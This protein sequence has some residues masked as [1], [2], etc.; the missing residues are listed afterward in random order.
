ML[1]AKLKLAV[2]AMMVVAALG[3]GGVAYQVSGPRPAQAAPESKPQPE[4]EALK[5][6]NELL[7]FNLQVILEK[8][9]ALEADVRALK[10]QAKA[11]TASS[12]TIIYTTRS[13]PLNTTGTFFS[14][15]VQDPFQQAEAALKA[16]REAKDPQA[17]RQAAA[18]LVAAAKLLKEQPQK[19][20]EKPSNR[21]GER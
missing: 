2:G 5:R 3:A 20:P 9:H 16:L 18:A 8:A 12:N 1:L 11:A 17:K 19:K 15:A 14:S 4:L 7:R 21:G 6:E 10:E 13:V